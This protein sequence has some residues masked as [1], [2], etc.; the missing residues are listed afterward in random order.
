[1]QLFKSQERSIGHFY[2]KQIQRICLL[3]LEPIKTFS[4]IYF[5]RTSFNIVMQFFYVLHDKGTTILFINSLNLKQ[6]N[7]LNRY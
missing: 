3:E 6:K 1:M 5:G 4:H 7:V 2:A